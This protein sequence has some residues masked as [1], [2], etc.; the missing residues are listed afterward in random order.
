MTATRLPPEIEALLRVPGQPELPLTP[1]KGDGGATLVSPGGA[2]RFP[3][4]GGVPVLVNEANSVFRIADYQARKVTT[5]D[6]DVER[7]ARRSL[8]QRLRSVLT[9]GVMSLSSGISDFGADAALAHIARALPGARV[10]VIGAGDH[11]LNV[12]P[13]LS[14]VYSDVAIG[15]LTMIVADAHDLP[16][17]PQSFDAVV[18]VAV[19]QHVLDPVRV[20]GEMQRV[21]KP[22][23]FAYAATPFIQ[24]VALGCYEFN[25]YTAL[26]HRR[27]FRWFS[28]ERAGIAIGPGTAL[29]WTFEYWLTSF[30]ETKAIRAALGVLA[31]LLAIP[32][33]YSDALLMNKRGSWDAASAFY[34]LG[35]LQETPLDDR[36][37]LRGYRGLGSPRYD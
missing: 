4:L 17:A 27:L 19:I 2:H 36:A 25:R 5:L 10:L 21:L 16:F 28:E 33:K 30:S 32:V 3:V 14:L 7:K 37:L 12:P 6:I 18:A 15:A 20:V 22:Q 34:F 23:G 29:A 26:G 13:G 35:R 8:R 31:R 9:Q 1:E 11:P 24:Q